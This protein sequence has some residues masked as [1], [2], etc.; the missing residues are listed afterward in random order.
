MTGRSLALSSIFL[1]SGDSGRRSRLG[2]G[3]LDAWVVV[4]KNSSSVA[5]SVSSVVLV[6]V[7]CTTV[8]LTVLSLL[9]EPGIGTDVTVVFL[10]FEA[11]VEDVCLGSSDNSSADELCLV[12]LGTKAEDRYADFRAV[13]RCLGGLAEL[14]A[15]GISGL[16]G[17]AFPGTSF[18]SL[19][20]ESETFT[21]GGSEILS[22]GEAR[23]S[24]FWVNSSI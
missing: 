17:L 1:R 8:V 23:A 4:L 3:D 11:V 9:S 18:I 15:F 6:V 13:C 7:V 5:L 22:D 2:D 12:G 19:S 10:S 21:F 16:A 14:E 24:K 20:G